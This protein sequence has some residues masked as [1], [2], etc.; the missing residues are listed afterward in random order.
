MFGGRSYTKTMFLNTNIKHSTYT[1]LSSKVSSSLSSSRLTLLD[2][3]SSSV[4]LSSAFRLRLIISCGG[5]SELQSP[6]P[7]DVFETVGFMI[8]NKLVTLE[9]L[10]SATC[11][12]LVAFLLWPASLKHSL[13]K[14]FFASVCLEFD[15]PSPSLLKISSLLLLSVIVTELILGNFLV[16]FLFSVILKLYG[17]AWSSTISFAA[18]QELSLAIATDRGLSSLLICLVVKLCSLRES[19]SELLSFLTKSSECETSL[20]REFSGNSGLYFSSQTEEMASLFLTLVFLMWCPGKSILEL[21]RF[22]KK[23]H[24]SFRLFLLEAL[25]A[26]FFIYKEK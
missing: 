2:D 13:S 26:F 23:I 9:P 20:H 17:F 15:G 11:W 16:P 10:V 12:E 4:V 19:L 22:N 25:L 18:G 24:F 21:L 8:P 6:S 1:L 14:L 3:F 7:T 5:S